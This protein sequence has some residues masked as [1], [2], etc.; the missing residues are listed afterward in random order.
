MNIFD[1][2]C[3]CL[4]FVVG[5]I[6]LVLGLL[7]AFVGCNAN[8]SLPPILGAIPALVGWGISKENI[9]KYEQKLKGGKYLIIATGN[10]DE[11]FQARK[12]LETTQPEELDYYLEAEPTA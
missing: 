5:I 3:A 1:K 12:I 9:I 11:V 6:L 4:A 8:F 7:G 10:P 2:I